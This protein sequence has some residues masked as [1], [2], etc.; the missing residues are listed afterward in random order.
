MSIYSTKYTR[1]EGAMEPASTRFAVIAET[2]LRRLY[3]EKW[4]RRLFILAW[5][6]PLFLVGKLYLELVMGQMMG[7]ES[8]PDAVFSMLFSSETTFVAIMLAAF[9]S[10]MINRDIHD[11]ALTLYFTRPVD[12]DQYLWGK[13]GAVMATVLSVTLVPG[14]IL[15]LA[16]LSMSPKSDLWH[17]LDITWRLLVVSL[18][19]A[20]LV[21]TLILLMSSLGKSS[22]FVGF[23]WLGIFVFGEIVRGLL[24]Q[25]LGDVPFL[26]ALSP[27]R[28]FIATAEFLLDGDKSALPAFVSAIALSALF[29][30]ALRVRL[31]VLKERQT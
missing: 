22:R 20:S 24:T 2:E 16:Q 12:V 21:S 9:G 8:A 4:V 31:G 5:I 3:K 17:F 11:K 19:N 7:D 15:A 25:V 6:P 27:S 26:D 29:Y 10:S 28:L 18:I 14:V 23:G 1:Y 30:L 13:L